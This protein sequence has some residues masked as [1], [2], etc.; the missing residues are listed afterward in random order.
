MTRARSI[1]RIEILPG[2]RVERHGRKWRAEIRVG[3]GQLRTVKPVRAEASNP[4]T[5]T[6]RAIAAA[7]LAILHSRAGGAGQPALRLA[8]EEGDT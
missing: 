4:A 2:S 6:Q 1:D 5:A 7:W 8:T 3:A